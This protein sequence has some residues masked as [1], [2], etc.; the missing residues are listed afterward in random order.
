MLGREGAVDL[1]SSGPQRPP[2]PTASRLG[3]ARRLLRHRSTRVA[4]VVLVAAAALAV[5]QATVRPERRVVG[6]GAP[7]PAPAQTGD[8]LSG[9]L[10]ST[11]PPSRDAAARATALVLGRYCADPGRYEFTLDPDAD[12]THDDFHHLNVLVADRQLTDSGP[13]T[14]LI[15]DWQRTAYRW[16]GPLTLAGGC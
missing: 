16:L 6:P 1:L 14:W 13:A 12:G 15:L 11:G 4:A 8:L 9:P 2:E 5:L 10:P 3:R 7:I